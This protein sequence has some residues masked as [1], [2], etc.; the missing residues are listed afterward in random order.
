L[1]INIT[2]FAL[3]A[4]QILTTLDAGTIQLIKTGDAVRL[5]AAIDRDPSIA[6]LRFGLFP[7]LEQLHGATGLHFAVRFRQLECLRVFLDCDA[8]LDATNGD[9]RTA[10]HDA[11][12]TGFSAAAQLMIAAG[13]HIDINAAAIMGDTSRVQEWLQ[14]DPALAN[15]RSTR[16]SPLGWAAFGNQCE[17]AAQL[18]DA[19]ARMDDCELMCAASCGHV[20]VA[21]YLIERGINIHALNDHGQTALHHAAAMAFTCDSSEMVTLLLRHGIDS[22]VR[23]NRDR[24]ALDLATAGQ[25]YQEEY[26]PANPRDHKNYAAVIGLLSAAPR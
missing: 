16:L 15:D 9:D 21:G 10:L 19:G 8:P 7:Q 6:Q 11:L 14:T 23:D 12:E 25:L 1:V 2:R 3:G 24:T 26:P 5:R 13:A 20:D 17:T 4:D 22:G 18:I